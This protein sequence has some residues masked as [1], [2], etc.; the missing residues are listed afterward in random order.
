[1][2]NKKNTND[3]KER[4][5]IK[6]FIVLKIKGHKAQTG[7]K[8]Y[9]PVWGKLNETLRELGYDPREIYEEMQREGKIKIRPIKGA[10]LLY[11][12]EDVTDT[13]KET[14]KKELLTFLL[15]NSK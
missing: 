10:V 9:N 14:L 2:K 4:E 11:L 5:K 3:V 8:G 15:K 12:P 13:Q 7:Y 6:E 1:M